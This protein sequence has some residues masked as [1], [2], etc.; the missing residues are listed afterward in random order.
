VQISGSKFENFKQDEGGIRSV[1]EFI[2]FGTVLT[3][4]G[5]GL[6]YIKC[7]TVLENAAFVES[8]IFVKT[9]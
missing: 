2:Y 4:G 8:K 3:K 6:N 1:E 9:N 7:P 5:G